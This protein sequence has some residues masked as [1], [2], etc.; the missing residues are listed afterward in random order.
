MKRRPPR[1]IARTM[2]VTFLTVAIILS[3]VFVVLTLDARDRVRTSETEKL[4]VS[5]GIFTALEAR[6][7]RDQLAVIATLAENPTLKAG[8]DTYVAENRFSAVDPTQEAELRATVSRE[9]QKLAATTDADVLAI[10]DT[11]DRVFAAAGSQ[12]TGWEPGLRVKLVGAR[13]ERFD[14]IAILPSGAFRVSGAPL[15]IADHDVGT[16]LMGTSLDARY[17]RELAALSHTGIV[18][19]VDDQI[20]A[21]TVPENVARELLGGE[22]MAGGTHRL[23]GEEYATRLLHESGPARIFMLSSIDAAAQSATQEALSAMATV[24]A[25]SVLLAALGSLWLARTLTEPIERVSRAIA[26]TTAAQ[27]YRR[28]VEPTGT[29]RE[30]DALTEAFNELMKGLTS[31][32]AETR[33]AYLGAIRALA[34]ALDAR[35]PYTAGHSERVSEVA[36]LI[37]EQMHLNDTDIEVI[38]LGALLHDIGKIGVGDDVLRKAGALT[39]DEF[40][41]IKR[42]P[43]LGARILRQVPFLAP[44]VPI[45]E[46]HHEQPD[47]KGYPYG[48][49]ADQI[50]LAASIVHVADTFDAMTTARAYRPARHHAIAL[51]EL[52][53][54]SGTQFDPACVEALHQAM[55]ASGISVETELEELLK[56]GA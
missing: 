40:E 46:L 38:R 32:E 52:R 21:R 8:L 34:V 23:N 35:D 55:P 50:P 10:L 51:A 26:D 44:Y 54:Y 47:G 2:T 11:E 27:S 3:V 22:V 19:I 43:G 6:R 53:R 13:A 41:Q 18:I 56:K 7:Q 1:L 15:N 20:V 4:Q 28:Y 17:A 45:V 16:L 49:R 24:A 31:A 30:L 42:H 37:A 36:V 39:R 33:A 9:V 12:D 25:G 14:S 29:S 5:E 48:L